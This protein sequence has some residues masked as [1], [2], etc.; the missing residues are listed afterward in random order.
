MKRDAFPCD[1]KKKAMIKIVEK[2]RKLGEINILDGVR[3]DLEDGWIL[4]MPSGTEPKIRI[5]VESKN[6][7]NELYNKASEI[8]RR[9]I[10]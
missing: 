5:T 1:D 8:V 4:V 7:C 9:A 10:S 6:R 3:V 2:L